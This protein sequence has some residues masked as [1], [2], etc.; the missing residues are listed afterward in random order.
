MK[1]YVLHYFSTMF[2][3]WG[4]YGIFSSR[5]RANEVGKEIISEE[6]ADEYTVAEEDVMD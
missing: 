1:V 3:A 5:E 6:I 4:I 2:K